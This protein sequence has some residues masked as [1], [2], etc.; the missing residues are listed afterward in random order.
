MS[1]SLYHLT[2]L[3]MEWTAEGSSSSGGSSAREVSIK[4]CSDEHG[5]GYR[6]I[7]QI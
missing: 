3:R 5:I 2:G 4:R 7:R 6:T 1:E